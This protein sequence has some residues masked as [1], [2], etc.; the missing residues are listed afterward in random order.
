MPSPPSWATRL[1]CAVERHVRSGR[2]LAQHLGKL[3]EAGYV[4]YEKSFAGG[5]PKSTF[6][7]RAAGYRALRQYLDA[8]QQVIDLVKERR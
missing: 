7:I 1:R 3:E 6:R 4:T 5:R 8:I 2:S